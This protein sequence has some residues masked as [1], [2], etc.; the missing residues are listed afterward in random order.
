MAGYLCGPDGEPLNGATFQLDEYL[1]QFEPEW[2]E[3]SAGR[4]ELTRDDPLLFALLFLGRHLRGRETNDR[5]TFADC[6]FEWARLART[7]M[8]PVTEPLAARDAFV[9]PRS[10]A[11]TTWWFLIVPLWAA[12]FGHVRFA[13]AF[14]QA[15]S[16]AEGH[17]QTMRAELD[18]SPLLREDFPLLCARGRARQVASASGNVADRQ[19]MIHT[20]SGFTFAARGLDSAV[21]GLKVGETRPDLLIID[22][23]EPDEAS[24]SPYLAKKRLG[25][26][27]DSVFALNI[28]ARVVMTGTVTMPGSIMHQLVKYNAGDISDEN[29][30]VADER[31]RVHHHRAILRNDDGTERSIWPEK[32]PL[33]WLASRRHTREFAKN[34]D[35]DPR[36]VT[37]DY[38]QAEDF[39]Y[40][41]LGD[42][43]TRW[44]LQVD[45]AVTTTGRSD[46][47]GLSIVA[48]RP[49]LR[50]S[51][52]YID[53]Q[54]EQ[55]WADGLPEWMDPFESQCEIVAAWGVRLAGEKLRLEVMRAISQHQKIRGVRCE[56]NQGGETWRTIFHDLPMGIKLLEHHAK[57]SKE[58][59]F[60]AALTRW[61]EARVIHRERFPILE[62][63]LTGFPL[64]PNDD[65]ADSAVHAVSWFMP[66]DGRPRVSVRSTAYA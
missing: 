9:A 19:S 61:H 54:A 34:Y 2:F 40:G 20:A 5:V 8:T 33:E 53:Q 15:S 28:Y 12:A 47:T 65:V 17:L 59:R 49:A 63:Q 50:P 14:A 31:I 27:T 36:A 42:L 23:A 66:T 48:F 29:K 64:L 7:W 41:T 3:T 10:A 24:Y 55:A 60:A 13:A 37:G 21:L 57:A 46:F 45:P 32:W 56:T 26:L 30:W 39:R 43:A 16:Q 62:D 51:R 35:N 11:K 18:T 6:H 4:R 38:W 25:T 44:I 1:G 58:A 52:E 22:D